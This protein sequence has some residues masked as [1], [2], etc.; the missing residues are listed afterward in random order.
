MVI[1]NT[2]LQA[3]AA[4]RL[5]GIWLKFAQTPFTINTLHLLVV[6]TLGVQTGTT[7]LRSAVTMISE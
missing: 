2:L 5:P 7:L 1:V 6:T 3:P 4:S